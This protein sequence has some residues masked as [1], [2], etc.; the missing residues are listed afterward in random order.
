MIRGGVNSAYELITLSK[1]D[2]QLDVGKWNP[3]PDLR[4]YMSATIHDSNSGGWR[5]NTRG[6]CMGA[7]VAPPVLAHCRKAF[8]Y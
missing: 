6:T 2:G 5:M 4:D 7:A 1:N 8:G 3:E